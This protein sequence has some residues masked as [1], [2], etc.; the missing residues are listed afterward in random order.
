MCTCAGRQQV[1]LQ[2]LSLLRPLLVYDDQSLDIDLILRD[3]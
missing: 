2:E 3:L 1:K